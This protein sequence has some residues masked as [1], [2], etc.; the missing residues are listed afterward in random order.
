MFVFVFAKKLTRIS[1]ALVLV[2]GPTGNT[3]I[4]YRPMA[5]AQNL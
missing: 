3:K 5:E 2:P 4:A 1:L